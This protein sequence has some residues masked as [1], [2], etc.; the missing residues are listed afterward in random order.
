MSKRGLFTLFALL[1]LLLTAC[2]NEAATPVAIAPVPVDTA[3]PVPTA[4]PRPTPTLAIV[5][6]GEWSIV[7]S[8]GANVK[9]EPNESLP[10]LEKLDGFTLVALQRSLANQSWVERAGGGWINRNQLVVYANE[11]EARR[12]LPK[13][14]AVPVLVPTFNPN[15]APIPTFNPNPVSVAASA[16][17]VQTNSDLTAVRSEREIVRSFTDA[18]GRS[19]KLTY[20]RG[21]GHGGDYG[22][23]HI[24]G[25]HI[26]GIWYDGGILTTFPQAVGAK[27]PA[28]VVDLIGKSLQDKNPDNQSGGR[29]TYI[30]AVPGTNQDVFTVVGSD[31]TIITSYPVSHGSK[32]MNG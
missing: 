5:A 9:A 14:T 21:T 22:W 27:T 17:K 8:T 23:A 18:Q 7:K 30:Y 12:S 28:V 20:G 11:V 16:P 19:I 10:T 4:T 24:L 2:G 6:T 29:R 26:N 15:P 1:S 13:P 31:G 25:K 3:T 32:D